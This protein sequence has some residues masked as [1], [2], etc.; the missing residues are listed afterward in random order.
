V[1]EPVYRLEGELFVPTPVAEGP[2]VADA[3]HGGPP[4]GL[5]ARAAEVEAAALGLRLLRLTVDLFRP[6]PMQPLELRTQRLREGR[7][8]ALLQ[9]SLLAGGVEVSRAHALLLRP[10]E[11]APSESC[12]VVPRGPEG[13]ATAPLVPEEVRG[14]RRVGFAAA[15]EV[16]WVVHDGEPGTAV[17][18][19]LP[20]PLVGGEPTTPLQQ[21]ATLSDFANATA[22]IARRDWRRGRPGF[23]NADSSLFLSRPPVGEWFCLQLDRVAD[24]DG[25]GAVEVALF[26]ASGPLGRIVQSRLVNPPRPA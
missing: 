23:I 21:I 16:R 4:I 25:V 6:V 13:I 15:I 26:D 1:R 7:R 19:R 24:Q 11:L 17:W 18:M 14:S 3:Q 8:I 22:I 9:I 10:G 2:W 5:A 12:E 20:V